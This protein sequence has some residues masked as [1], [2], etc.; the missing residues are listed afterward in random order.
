MNGDWMEYGSRGGG[1]PGE[2][3][4]AWRYVWNRFHALGVTNAVWVWAPNWNS[5]PDEPWNDL[6]AYYPGDRYVDWVGVDFYGLMWDDV[7]VATQLDSVYSSF[8]YKPVMVAETAAADCANYV[9]GAVHSKDQWIEQLFS[10][11]MAH[12]AVHA[13]YWFEIDKEADWRLGSCPYPQALDAFRRGISD[14][15]F[16]SRAGG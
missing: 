15:R 12:P 7:P 16:L 4:G 11:L 8:S 2:F 3:V 10:E 9:A 14:P 1:D 6:H 13:L 5:S